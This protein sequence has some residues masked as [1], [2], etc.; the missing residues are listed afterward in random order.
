MIEQINKKILIVEDDKNF[1]SILQIKFIS[2]GFS[3]VTAKDGE[4]GV[5]MAEEEKPDLILSD[6]LMPKMDGVE[7]AKKIR[8]FN[9]NI[10]IVF[11]TNIQDADYT[12]NIKKLGEFD[13]W[14]KAELTINDIVNKVKIKLGLEKK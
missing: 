5:K 7:M 14:I 9:K 13:Y 4:E 12:D 10:L 1:F 6:V 11:L 8:E 2:E 3:V